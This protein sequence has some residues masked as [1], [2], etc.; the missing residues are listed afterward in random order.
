MKSTVFAMLLLAF[1]AGLILLQGDFH[2]DTPFESL[3]KAEM[4]TTQGAGDCNN[5]A[6]V[7]ST[8]EGSYCGPHRCRSSWS[9]SVKQSASTYEECS[10]STTWALHCTGWSHD[11]TQNCAVR[12]HYYL[13]GCIGWSNTVDVPRFDIEWTSC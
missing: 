4:L 8:R 11:D 9:G 5:I 1:I 12:Y 2:S 10:D 3:S 7:I 13:P 6:S